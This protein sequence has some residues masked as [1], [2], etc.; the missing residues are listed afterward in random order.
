MLKLL[1]VE[2]RLDQLNKKHTKTSVNLTKQFFESHY[3]NIYLLK[4]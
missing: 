3:Q 4:V 1:A 2:Y